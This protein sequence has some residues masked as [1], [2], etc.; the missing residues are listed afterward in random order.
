MR[1]ISAKY[2]AN[3]FFFCLLV[4][5]PTAGCRR[6]LSLSERYEILSE[7]PNG[8]SLT[9][10]I[11][12]V[13]DNQLNY[14]YGDPIWLRSGLTDKFVKVAIRPVQQDLFGQD[15]L[16]RALDRYG[17][18][19]PVIHL[20]DAAN[21]ACS[22]E[23]EAFLEIMSAD[24]KAWVMAPGNHDAYLFGNTHRLQKEWTA[25]CRGD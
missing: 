23:F 8:F 11:M 10:N 16:R 25:T 22:G 14:L 5:L 2:F 4:L 20:G 24:T 15:I 9:K 21:M 7:K 18:R 13:A 17:S 6:K 3:C 1:Q 19:L 12:P